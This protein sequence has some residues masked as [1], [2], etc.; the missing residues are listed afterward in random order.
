MDDDLLKASRGNCNLSSGRGGTGV[1][2]DGALLGFL[3]FVMVLCTGGAW[4]GWM[5]AACFS[6]HTTV[7]LRQKTATVIYLRRWWK[8]RDKLYELKGSTTTTRWQ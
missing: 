7:D 6:A 1:A 4:D 8:L 2:R 3:N 5:F